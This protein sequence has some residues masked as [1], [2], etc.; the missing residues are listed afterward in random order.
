[1]RLANGG[2]LCTSYLS[3]EVR[4]NVK[5]LIYLRGLIKQ[6]VAGSNPFKAEHRAG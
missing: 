6:I 5:S 2:P 1:M 3:C 4:T